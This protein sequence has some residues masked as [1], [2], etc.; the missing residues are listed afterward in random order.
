VKQQF[1]KLSPSSYKVELDTFHPAKLQ[2]YCIPYHNSSIVLF[3]YGQSAS[4]YWC[5]APPSKAHDQIF[6]TVRHLR[7]SCCGAP[8]LMRERVCNLRVQFAVTLRFKS[9]RTHDHILLPHSLF[10]A[11]YDSQSYGGDIPTRLHKR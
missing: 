2:I 1:I 8:S 9:H 6:I 10:V 4:F 11:S 3:Q 5:L 7:S